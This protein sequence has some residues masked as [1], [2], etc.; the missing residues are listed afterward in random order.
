MQ[1]DVDVVRRPH[2]LVRDARRAHRAQDDFP[3]PQRAIDLAVPPAFVPELHDV[4]IPRIELL[5]NRR[6]P[7]LRV[8]ETGRELKEKAR[9]PLPERFADVEVK[10][11]DEHRRP[12]HPEIVRDVAVDLDAVQKPRRRLAD[13]ALHRRPLRPG[14]KRRVQLDR[15]EM[16]RVVRKPFMRRRRQRIELSP[17]A[18]VEPPGAADVKFFERGRPHYQP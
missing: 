14:I 3:P 13:P 12:F 17:P 7:L 15:L 2:Q 11:L 5:A 18:P 9:H 1:A 4:A 8:P 10:L 6:Q 16:L